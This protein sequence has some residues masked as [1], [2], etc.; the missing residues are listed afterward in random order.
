[1]TTTYNKF[2]KTIA[3][4]L[5]LLMVF[6][7]LP[8]PAAF[9]DDDM[10]VGS[11]ENGNP[12]ANSEEPADET[13][14]ANQEPINEENSEAG[15]GNQEKG[16]TPEDGDDSDLSGEVSVEDVDKIL[17]SEWGLKIGFFKSDAVEGDAYVVRAINDSYKKDIAR[18]QPD[19]ESLDELSWESLAF[20]PYSFIEDGEKAV[21]KLLGETVTAALG[22]SSSGIYFIRVFILTQNEHEIAKYALIASQDDTLAIHYVFAKLSDE[23]T[24]KAIVLL[25]NQ[26]T[27][28]DVSEFE[29]TDEIS[30]EDIIEIRDLFHNDQVYLSSGVATYE[31]Y[32]NA[33]LDLAGPQYVELEPANVDAVVMDAPVE[34]VV[35]ANDVEDASDETED[36]HETEEATVEYPAI[37]SIDGLY[38]YTLDDDLQAVNITKY[39]GADTTAVVYG[40]YAVGEKL[41]QTYIDSK[42]TFSLNASVTSISFV[43]GVKLSNNTMRNLFANCT[44]L[45]SVDLSGLDTTGVTDM[46][47][48]F[49]G[50]SK[51]TSLDVSSFDTSAVTI[52]YGMFNDCVKLS[53]IIG[54]ESWDTHS[55]ENMMH[56]F[57]KLGY[58]VSGGI[59]L[60]D[61]SNWDLSNVTNSGWCFQ[62]C[63]A[64]DIRLPDNI[65]TMSAGFFN[66]CK[67]LTMTEF[68][69]PAGVEKI[70]YSHV[71]YDCGGDSFVAINVAEGN[72][73]YKSVDGILYSA[74]GKELLGVPGGK[75]FE[76][77]VFEI[78]E[79]VA[80]IAELSFSRNQNITKLIL[81]DSYVISYVYEKYDPRY[82]VNGDHGN[83]N[84]GSDL[85]IALYKFSAV[86][87]YEVKA[88]NPNYTSID[89]IL[90]SK[91]GTHL[92]AVP[93][94]YDQKLV[95]PDGVTKWDT[96]AIWNMDGKDDVNS[97]LSG[98][99]GVYIP[100]SMQ[101]ISD[102]QLNVINSLRRNS[103]AS[104]ASAAPLSV[105]SLNALRGA[106]SILGGD[107]EVQE[108]QSTSFTIEVD[109]NN[110][111]YRLNENGELERNEWWYIE[112][113]TLVIGNGNE[114]TVPDLDSYTETSW[115]WYADRASI[116]SVRCSGIVHASANCS[117]M[118]SGLNK[119]KS[120]DLTG[121]DTS[122]TTNMMCMFYKCSVVTNIN[123]SGFVTDSVTNMQSM[124]NS[125][126]KLLSVDASNFDTTNVTSFAYMFKG[127]EVMSSVDISSFTSENATTTREMFCNCKVLES[128]TFNPGF[129]ASKLTTTQSMFYRCYALQSLDLSMF[130]TTAALTNTQ[131]MFEGCSS[132]VSLDLSN[133]NTKAN[134][135]RMDSTFKECA[136]LRSITLGENFSFKG[137]NITKASY[138][139]ILPHSLWQNVGNESLVRQ[140]PAQLRDNYHTDPTNYA[141]EWVV[142][143]SWWNVDENGV[144]TIGIGDDVDFTLPTQPSYSTTS[145]PW[146]PDHENITSVRFSG[147]VHATANISYMFADLNNVSSIDLTGFD[148]S[149]TT[150]IRN[151]FYNCSS[152]T[153]INWGSFSTANVTNMISVFYNCSSLETIDLSSFTTDKVTTMNSM[154]KG[155]SSLTSIDVSG[156]NTELVTDMTSMFEGCSTITSLDLSRFHG[157]SLT[158]T[159]RMFY[160]CKF[161]AS[162]D[163]SNMNTSKCTDMSYMFGGCVRLST[164][165]HCMSGENATTTAFMFYCCYALSG[166]SFANLVKEK[167]A[168]ISYMFVYC[169]SLTEI[170]TTGWNTSKVSNAAHAFDGCTRLQTLDTSG[171]DTSSLKTANAMFQLCA[172]LPYLDVSN[173]NM[174]KVTNC[175]KMFLN[176]YSL[177]TLDVSNW[178]IHPTNSNG[179]NEMFSGCGVEYL[180]VTRFSFANVNSQS[181]MFSDELQMIKVNQQKMNSDVG[182][183]G[184]WKN[185]DTDEIVTE[186]QLRSGTL[187]GTYRREAVD[188][189]PVDAPEAEL[190]SDIFSTFKPTEDLVEA[191]K[192]SSFQGNYRIERTL[193][194]GKL[195]AT[196]NWVSD[197]NYKNMDIDI[198][199]TIPRSSNTRALYLMNTCGAHG[200]SPTVAYNQI[201]ELLKY[202]DNVDVISTV[203]PGVAYANDLPF[204]Y[205][206]DEVRPIVRHLHQGDDIT[207][208]LAELLA[209]MNDA[210]HDKV[211]SITNGHIGA[212]MNFAWLE[213]YFEEYEPDCI[214][215][216]IDGGR[217]FSGCASYDLEGLAQMFYGKTAAELTD[218][219]SFD[220]FRY[221][222]SVIEKLAEYQAN[223]KYVI[224]IS[225]SYDA[226]GYKSSN[227]ASVNQQRA[228]TYAGLAILAPYKFVNDHDAI[229]AFSSG[230]SS[231]TISSF[232]PSG[233]RLYNYGTTLG[234]AGFQFNT[235]SATLENYVTEAVNID[236]SSAQLIHYDGSIDPVAPTLTWD[237]HHL[238]TTVP[239][240]KSGDIIS[241]HIE[242]TVNDGATGANGFS[243]PDGADGRTWKATNVAIPTRLMN[244]ANM[245][246]V[247]KATTENGTV[248]IPSPVLYSPTGAI[249]VTVHVGGNG[250][251][252]NKDWNYTVTFTTGEGENTTPYTGFI[253]VTDAEGNTTRVEITDGT[254]TFDLKHG[255]HIVLSDVPAGVSYSIVEDNA[256]TDDYTTTEPS[257][258]GTVTDAHTDEL[259]FEN[260]R[261]IGAVTVDVEVQG[262]AASRA[263]DWEYVITLTRGEGEDATPFVGTV[264]I[265][266]EPVEITDGTYTF[267]L[268]HGQSTTLDDIPVGVHYSVVETNADTDGY[269]T[270]FTNEENVIIIE[271]QHSHFINVR[272][273]IVPTGVSNF[274]AGGMA[275]L[276]IAVLIGFT[277]V[278]LTKKKREDPIA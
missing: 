151:L 40:K 22:D 141:G 159:P 236:A 2:H 220:E 139:A 3:M 96:Q 208:D 79:G 47:A 187:S 14:P 85:S 268:K 143:D 184:L 49:W 61:L 168:N 204:D 44:S 106:D 256:N 120:I 107:D 277:Y 243:E 30:V 12:V 247:I 140:T 225:P 66:H 240:V 179:Y 269:A 102:D 9:A 51:L 94:S 103:L 260:I 74:D 189:S 112:D 11:E 186:Q 254:Y 90:Y 27:Q 278:F 149:S 193:D 263:K 133:F 71:F 56:M 164:L 205:L 70:G 201:R 274:A 229:V 272:N 33:I 244:L 114:V 194:K 52:T 75:Q 108:S 101:R 170:D 76:N 234:N 119:A 172:S 197:S 224:S 64:H 195:L 142:D 166:T 216:S 161:L 78:P 245:P 13:A 210:G 50:C 45:T 157:D 29:G 34:D 53:N 92:V 270:T 145:W 198:L 242:A 63:A 181:A 36:K 113:G 89:G 227:E 59:T 239:S 17:N 251:D 95:I 131:S 62:Y 41:Y 190:D 136:S 178:Q 4:L 230:S 169:T 160:T 91:D 128:I 176:C 126:A 173:F 228:Y 153:T 264:I 32:T 129:T 135:S 82:E 38:E 250:G 215:V 273:M 138:Q 6:S 165:N 28:V 199:Y 81:P 60:L 65:K 196:S 253:D 121:F 57:N 182:L 84:Y 100:A 180:D 123:V 252:E 58:K 209:Y 162:I 171:F 43:G 19:E 163:I 37:A 98:C 262:N 115:P 261:N 87:E 97:K 24:E 203:N 83:L 226:I 104:H 223:G 155:C 265:D 54:L 5:V 148:T 246:N 132:M 69:V 258:S 26:Y 233:Q 18:T 130:A 175:T 144:L 39:V 167:N 192:Q 248:I 77:G 105:T 267:T 117:Y 200:Y 156:F 116:T 217:A 15:S 202:Y 271:G 152:L 99:S 88:T 219:F 183:Y 1:M 72:Q 213:D 25:L 110:P 93:V 86:S 67:N 42:T 174:S 31:G 16:T 211:F 21:D 7:C 276:A 266:G 150:N 191:D 249:D 8:M 221:P 206:Y 134:V 238:T 212:T 20:G 275:V 218:G 109:P 241:I 259:E 122:S 222:M 154:F 55:L 185:V 48:V 158:L 46:S 214:Y 146:H 255:E 235:Y 124:F 127:C 118:F 35:N 68:T 257:F 231:R 207:D 188:Y 237:G 137:R 111:V 125:C 147:T 23:L 73:N 10:T 232:L 80:F 177:R